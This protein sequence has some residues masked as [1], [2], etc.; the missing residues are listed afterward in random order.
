MIHSVSSE[1]AEPNG[2]TMI[3]SRIDGN[4]LPGVFVDAARAEIDLG[5]EAADSIGG[6]LRF[7]AWQIIPRLFGQCVDELA[8]AKNDI[9][10][11]CHHETALSV[12][13]RLKPEFERMLMQLRLFAS[14][15]AARVPLD[16]RS[17]DADEVRQPRRPEMRSLRIGIG[18]VLV[19]EASNFPFAF[20]ALG[21]DVG[22]AL[23]AGCPVIVKSHPGHAGTTELLLQC[24]QRASAKVGVPAAL[25]SLIHGAPHVVE[26]AVKHPLL[27]GLAFTGSRRVGRAILQMASSRRRPLDEVSLE[28]GSI[29]PV[30]VSARAMDDHVDQRARVLAASVLQGGGQFCTKPG[31]IVGPFGGFDC[32]FVR[33]LT[34]AVN[35]AQPVTLLTDGISNTWSESMERLG[36]TDRVML[37]T[38]K[39]GSGDAAIP[40][41][42]GCSIQTFLS[43]PALAEEVFGPATILVSC[44]ENEFSSLLD[45]LEGELT[46]TLH[47]TDEDDALFPL[48]PAAF[49]LK[50]RA[51]Y[52]Q[53]HAN[54]R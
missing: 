21:G 43:T 37:L 13:V 9:I 1:L 22:S 23:A 2:R 33:N 18:T 6:D 7:N 10:A 40:A 48:P 49:G 15:A 25:L 44:G 47:F 12:E 54:R 17:V 51:Y 34:Y 46:A 30:F 39:R 29:N 42:F 45:S 52:L 50:S 16:P 26:L 53:W 24:F 20:G 4:L 36:S 8:D 14:L 41:I 32:E 3:R 11:R 28:M 38:H 19:L 31:L 5:F 35:A 27:R